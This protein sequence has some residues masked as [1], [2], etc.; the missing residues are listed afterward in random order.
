MPRSAEDRVRDGWTVRVQGSNVAI[1]TVSCRTSP[2]FT[3]TD[4]VGVVGGRLTFLI[5]CMLPSCV[6]IRDPAWGNVEKP[7]QMP[8]LTWYLPIAAG[9]TNHSAQC[10]QQVHPPIIA[11]SP[12]CIKL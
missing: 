3:L 12:F 5:P 7:L 1:R 2:C 11:L 8:E 4:P 9:K 6:Y 10:W